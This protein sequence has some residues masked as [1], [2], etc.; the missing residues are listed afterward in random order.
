MLVLRF[1]L[2]VIAGLLFSATIANAQLVTRV[3][4]GDTIV[5]EGVGSVRLIGV[6]GRSARGLVATVPAPGPPVTVAVPHDGTCVV[7][8]PRPSDVALVETPRWLSASLGKLSWDATDVWCDFR[9]VW[10]ITL[11]RSGYTAKLIE[12]HA[13]Q[14]GLAGS[15]WEGLVMRAELA[16]DDDAAI[17]LWRR[18]R[19]V[20]GGAR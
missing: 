7:L 14:P 5:V 3:I 16:S 15:S 19:E 1:L 10:L 12:A 20:A 11:S 13:P 8:G 17:E 9:P 18:Y 2:P 4:D 6:E